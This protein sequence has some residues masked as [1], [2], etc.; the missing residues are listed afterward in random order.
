[1]KPS[2]DACAGVRRQG[3][4]HRGERFA[5][6]SA[7]VQEGVDEAAGVQQAAGDLG[8]AQLGAALEVALGA[9][10]GVQRW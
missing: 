6:A 3:Q 10:M 5:A 4:P 2:R 7:G 9:G 8:R 1:M